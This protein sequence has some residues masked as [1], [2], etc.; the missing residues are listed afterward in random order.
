MDGM[1]GGM[2][3]DM[4]DMGPHMTL[5]PKSPPNAGDA[6]RAARLVATLRSAI[7]KYQDYRVAEQDGYVPFLAS[8]PQTQYHFTN[9]ANGAAAQFAFDPTKPTS[10]LYDKTSDGYRL[11]GAMYTAPR[12]ATLADL[13]ARVPLSVAQWHEHVNFCKAPPQAGRD[14]YFGPHAQFGLKGSIATADACTSAGGTF[15]PIIYNWMVHVYPYET[16]P[17]QIWKVGH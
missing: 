16:D 9:W 7:Q 12:S 3:S 6:E 5:T 8:V 2:Q 11:A 13:N 10:L 4:H 14:A 1:Q 15:Y 17:A